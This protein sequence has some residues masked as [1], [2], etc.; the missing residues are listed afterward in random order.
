M[1]V[2]TLFFLLITWVI[3]QRGSTIICGH[4]SNRHEYILT[5]IMSNG[6][7]HIHWS[8]F[9]NIPILFVVHGWNVNGT[10]LYLSDMWNN[11][12]GGGGAYVIH[13]TQKKSS[14]I[15]QYKILHG[16]DLNM[17]VW[18]IW[19]IIC[20]KLFKSVIMYLHCYQIVINIIHHNIQQ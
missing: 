20:I 11:Q 14:W 12:Y 7:G 13:Y 6:P 2:C 3:P 19:P 4:L 10:D 17:T 5:G 8:Q 9:E 18:N 16:H 1:S 15:H